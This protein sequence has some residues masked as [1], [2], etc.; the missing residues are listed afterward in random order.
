MRPFYA[1]RHSLRHLS[2]S[3]ANHRGIELSAREEADQTA[4]R[5]DPQMLTARA[6]P[7]DPYAAWLEQ[8]EADLRR[9]DRLTVRSRRERGVCRPAVRAS[10]SR[11][12]R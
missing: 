2:A 12:G 5:H 3:V 10:R 9:D 7:A 8:R 11:S 6:V 4:S 1:S